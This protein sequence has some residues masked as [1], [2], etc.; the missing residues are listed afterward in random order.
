MLTWSH[1]WLLLVT[2]RLL[3]APAAASMAACLMGAR[4]TVLSPV[5]L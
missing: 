2:E 3:E 1:M 5:A 4:P